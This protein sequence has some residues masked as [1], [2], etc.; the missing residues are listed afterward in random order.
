M[1]EKYSQLILPPVALASCVAGCIVRD[2]RTAHL[3]NADR[4]NYFPA[5][6]LFSVTLILEGDLHVAP[7]LV[8]LE[9]L[10]ARPVAPKILVTPPQH[11]PNMSW[12][13]GPVWAL[14]VAFYP[15]AW[16]R[17]GGT[18]DGVLPDRIVQT[19]SQLN[20]AQPDLNW[21]RF[22]HD[23]TAI[24]AQSTGRDGLSEWSGSHLIKDWTR[25][26]LNQIGQT[27]RGRSLRSAQRRLRRWT[28]QNEQTLEFFA[29]VDEV[30]RLISTNPSATP[31]EIAIDAGFADQSHM[32]RAL[33]RATGFSPVLLNQKI[34]TEEAFWCYRL[35]G[36][37]F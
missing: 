17:L 20:G 36:Q 26:L 7:E 8:G 27:G 37:R 34:A 19:V 6:P 5:S 1:P 4:I 31:V 29:K 15:D 28:G 9:Q 23:M 13:P 14:T 24:W 12:S 11:Q 16:Q 21:P 35:L 2:T 18:L 22:W 10:R 25:H 3:S 30:N 32:G 33:K